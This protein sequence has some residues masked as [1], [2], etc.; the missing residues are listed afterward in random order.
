M[1]IH[2]RP[3]LPPMLPPPPPKP[4]S[5]AFQLAMQTEELVKTAQQQEARRKKLFGARKMPRDMD[6]ETDPDEN[7]RNHRSKEKIV[8]RLA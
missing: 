1:K 7:E 2:M 3:P 8:D 6:D 4:A 5:T